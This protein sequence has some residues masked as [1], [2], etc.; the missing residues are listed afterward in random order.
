MTPSPEENNLIQ[1][2][3]TFPQVITQISSL[4]AVILV[5]S[6]VGFSYSFQIVLFS[7]I[8]FF[9]LSYIAELK[10]GISNFSSIIQL[11]SIQFIALIS[12]LAFSDSEF[13]RGFDT[14]MLLLT[15]SCIFIH[16]ATIDRK[17]T[18]SLN[19]AYFF[20]IA[21]SAYS[22]IIENY[23]SPDFLSLI[24]KSQIIITIFLIIFTIVK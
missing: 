15:L 23:R 7:T 10:I 9:S 17:N 8:Y 18:L 16:F 21:N 13:I 6:L 22:L 14:S 20:S 12:A 1:K 4:L 2:T 11:I 3:I 24:N 19:Y 5:L